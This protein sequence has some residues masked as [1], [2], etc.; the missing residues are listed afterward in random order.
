MSYLK[1]YIRPFLILFCLLNVVPILKAQE[2]NGLDI[3][4]SLDSSRSDS[5]LIN[6]PP[7]VGSI[8]CFKYIPPSRKWWVA[9][10]HAAVWAGT[11]IALNKAWY[12]GY[13]R[14]GF[15]LFD[16][17]KEWNQ[18]DKAGHIWTTY[19]LGRLSGEVWE[20]AGLR[21]NQA[22]WL[23][24]ASAMAFQSIIEL[25][26][27]YSAKWGFSWWDIAANTVGAAAYVSQELGW[28]EQRIQIKMGYFPY[29]YPS[30]LKNRQKELFGAGFAERILKDYN[31][32]TYWL[33]ANLDRF[34]PTAKLP[35]W[36]NVSVGYSSD[37]ML[38][39]MSNNWTEADGT[40][41]NRNDIARVRRYYFSAD[42]DLTRIPTRKKW[43]RTIFTALNAIKIPAPALEYNN[44]GGFRFHW[45]HQ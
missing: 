16:D 23:G 41:V 25:Q 20:W 43:V 37:L 14:Q 39:G 40:P 9:G 6:A 10:G 36:L 22:V 27:A 31:G 19:Q 7:L 30:E 35:K 38:G 24:G 45:L 2:K 13:E 11:Y 34:F 29:N 3:A 42:V 18:L 21:H 17:S 15:H 1:I 4:G 32:Q 5:T 12:D 8:G 33:S 44:S 26:D 28:K